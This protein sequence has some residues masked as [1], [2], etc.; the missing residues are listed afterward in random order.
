MS[1]ETPGR[2]WIIDLIRDQYDPAPAHYRLGDSW[3][4]GAEA[5]ADAILAQLPLLI[6]EQAPRSTS[7]R[8]CESNLVGL[9]GECIVCGAIQ[10]EACQAPRESRK[11][12]RSEPPELLMPL[13]QRTIFPSD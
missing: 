4:D 11:N 10:G 2:Q 9:H 12:S 7:D 6:A 1:S 13:K 8:R 3:D 5:I